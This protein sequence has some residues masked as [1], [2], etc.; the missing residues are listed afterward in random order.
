M[1]SK[2]PLPLPF[3]VFSRAK[4]LSP[5]LDFIMAG[6]RYSQLSISQVEALAGLSG[7]NKTW[8]LLVAFVIDPGL[9]YAL[10]PF[11][12]LTFAHANT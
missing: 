5:V 6:I 12:L 7:F 4:A 9:F 3:F 11:L 2:L 10:S 1:F 8:P